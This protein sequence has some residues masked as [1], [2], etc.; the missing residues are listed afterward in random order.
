MIFINKYYDIIKYEKRRSED[1]LE[2]PA[3]RAVAF[4][5]KTMK[6]TLYNSPKL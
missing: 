5:V 3:L 6:T 4:N 1:L 2:Q